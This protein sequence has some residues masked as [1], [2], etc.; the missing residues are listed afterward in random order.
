[1]GDLLSYSGITTKVRAMESHLITDSQF[2]E[3]QPLKPFLMQ[4][5]I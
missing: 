1:M 2:R 3:W 5:N 4:W